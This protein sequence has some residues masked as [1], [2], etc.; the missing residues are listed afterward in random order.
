MTVTVLGATGGQGGHVVAA[1]LAQG[2]PVRAVVRDASEQRAHALAGQ[3]V[4]VVEGDMS[5]VASLTAAF[6]GVDAAFG[7]TTPFE[8][9]LDAEVRQG[10]AIIEAARRAG[11]PHL[12]MASVASAD[13]HTGIP[14]FETKARVE[15][16][17][18]ASEIPATV[19]APSYFYDNAYGSVDEIAAG[20]MTTGVPADKPLQQVSRRDYGL[21][22]AA[23]IAD[24]ERWLGQ[25]IEVAG[26]EPTPAQMA[27]VIGRVAGGLVEVRVTP[28]E[29][30]RA[31]HSDMGA[32]FV[33][34]AETGY[35]VDIPRLR[36]EFPQ[37]SWTPFAEWA[38]EQRW[39]TPRR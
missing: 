5:D 12:V 6:T 16:A 1:L 35:Q 17:L 10:E 26:D 36:A 13:R 30:L 21:L 2:V 7:L 23:V 29:S 20:V 18:T 27:E 15:A 37:I 34:L 22:V 19:V 9:G 32:M 25:R 31:S 39:P 24:R 38:A 28:L 8:A 3:G 14:H 33:Y 4:E 11:L